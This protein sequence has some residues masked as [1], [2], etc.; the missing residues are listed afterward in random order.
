MRLI[1]ILFAAISIAAPC[2]AIDY[3]ATRESVWA[4][5]GGGAPFRGNDTALRLA[6][7]YS[8]FGGPLPKVDSATHYGLQ[9][10]QWERA[11]KAFGVAWMADD[12]AKFLRGLKAD[13]AKINN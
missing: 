7:E 2:Q 8:V 9:L 10:K 11:L 4:R 1:T 3:T 5:Y 13:L 12:Y 6:I